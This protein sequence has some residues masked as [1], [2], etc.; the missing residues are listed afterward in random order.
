MSQ[1]SFFPSLGIHLL[2]EP[3]NVCKCGK[4][5]EKTEKEEQIFLSIVNAVTLWNQKGVKNEDQT[6]H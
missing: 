6:D 2:L 4:L 5:T 3:L 1:V